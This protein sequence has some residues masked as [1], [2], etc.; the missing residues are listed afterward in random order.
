MNPETIR[1]LVIEA[2]QTVAPEMEASDINPD[3]D[4]REACDIDS[5]DFL[6]FILA[7]KN[8]SGVSIPEID[9]PQ[10]NTLNKMVGYLSHKQTL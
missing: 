4:L 6:N 3:E 7:L 2:V 8:S 9:Y 1:T 5:M 10:I